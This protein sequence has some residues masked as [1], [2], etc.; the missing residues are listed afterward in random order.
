MD[1]VVAKRIGAGYVDRPQ[2]LEVP[3]DTL[4][5]LQ[6]SPKDVDKVCVRAQDRLDAVLA[7]YQSA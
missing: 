2:D 3:R 4:E 6:L 1:N 5:R 7:Q